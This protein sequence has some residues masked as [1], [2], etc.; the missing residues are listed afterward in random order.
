MITGRIL[1]HLSTTHQ[2]PNVARDVGP[3]RDETN[4]KIIRFASYSPG[5]RKKN[6]EIEIP[7]A[8]TGTEKRESRDGTGRGKVE[9][10]N[11]MTFTE[12]F[13]D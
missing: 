13:S 9:T 5:K 3:R 8:K 6:N 7:L 11:L 4:I 1:P 2:S 10:F 12:E